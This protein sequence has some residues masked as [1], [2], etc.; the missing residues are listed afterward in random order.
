MHRLAHPSAPSRKV[1]LAS[2]SNDELA[3]IQTEDTFFYYSISEEVRY[4]EFRGE[5]QSIDAAL[6]SAAGAGREITVARSSRLSTKC[7]PD[8]MMSSETIQ[9]KVAASNPQEG[10]DQ[11][12]SDG[13]DN[14]IPYFSYLMMTFGES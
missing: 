3:T 12:D 14:D 5:G 11:Q 4:A 8:E 2:L 6:L 13:D 10:S 1:N 7:Y 9:D